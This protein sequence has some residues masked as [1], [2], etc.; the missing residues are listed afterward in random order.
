MF[1][2]ANFF[3]SRKVYHRTFLP[4]SRIVAS[5]GER[6]KLNPLIKHE[7]AAQVNA[8]P[9]I[10]DALARASSLYVVFVSATDFRA[11]PKPKDKKRS[12][13]LMN[14]LSEK[15]SVIL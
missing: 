5:N 9:E 11:E 7:L 1:A 6:A 14:H 4:P 8:F 13:R 2:D 15:M 10:S 12:I 3:S